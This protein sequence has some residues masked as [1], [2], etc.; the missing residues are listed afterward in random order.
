MRVCVTAYSTILD[1]DEQ[2]KK[3]QLFWGQRQRGSMSHGNQGNACCD[4]AESS[5]HLLTSEFFMDAHAALSCEGVLT[6]FSDNE[7]YMRSLA[8]TIGTLRSSGERCFE[9]LADVPAE[10]LE[11]AE[12]MCGLLICK[13]CPPA[14]WA[15]FLGP[16]RCCWVSLVP[17]CPK[18]LHTTILHVIQNHATSGMLKFTRLN[19]VFFLLTRE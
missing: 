4:D 2:H 11:S 10:H 14:D 7:E 8:R 19:W 16:K 17:C 18:E 6:I 15:A 12:E 5:L 9:P 1:V 13:G 3:K